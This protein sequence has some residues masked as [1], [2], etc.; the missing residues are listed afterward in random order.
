MTMAETRIMVSRVVCRSC[1]A[2]F[3]LAFEEGAKL[4]VCEYCHLETPITD[5][6]GFPSNRCVSCNHPI[7]NHGRDA[8]CPKG[9]PK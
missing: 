6:H 9:V 5:P 7:E 4:A 8:I 1:A 3:T 2:V